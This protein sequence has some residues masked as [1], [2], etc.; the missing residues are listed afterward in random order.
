MQVEFKKSFESLFLLQRFGHKSEIESLLG[1][2]S[3]GLLC[4]GSSI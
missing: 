1:L 3:S 4:F 2:G